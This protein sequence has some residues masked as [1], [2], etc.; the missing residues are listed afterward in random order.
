MRSFNRFRMYYLYYSMTVLFAAISA[1]VKR[2]LHHTDYTTP[3]ISTNKLQ[4]PWARTA[5]RLFWQITT[6]CPWCSCFGDGVV[7]CSDDIARTSQCTGDLVMQY[8]HSFVLDKTTT[9]GIYYSLPVV[10][11]PE[12]DGRTPMRIWK[13]PIQLALDFLVFLCLPN[14]NRLSGCCR[15]VS[16]LG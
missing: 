1:S 6:L 15:E 13:H 3:S 14:C 5:C 9:T 7:L 2:V 11:I 8:S 16:T 10:G 4:F 12:Q